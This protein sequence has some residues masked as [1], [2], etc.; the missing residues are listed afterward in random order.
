V[1]QCVVEQYV[2]QLIQVSRD[3]GDYWVSSPLPEVFAFGA[4]KP[5]ASRRATHQVHESEARN[6]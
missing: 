2:S 4:G 5:N 3:S 6:R 1:R